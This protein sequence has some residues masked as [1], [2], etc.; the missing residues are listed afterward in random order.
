MGRS[1][2]LADGTLAELNVDSNTLAVDATNDRV[3]IGTSSPA[4]QLGFPIGNNTKISQA[5][6]TAHLAGNVGSL[7]LTISD[8]GG[9]SG[10]FVNNTHNGTYSSQD[11]T[12]LTAQGGISVATERMRIDSSGRVTM[13]YQPSFRAFKTSSWSTGNS[14]ITGWSTFHNTGNHLNTSTGVFTA[15]VAGVYQVSFHWLSDNT[16]TQSDVHIRLNNAPNNGIRTRSASSGGHQTTSG[17]QSIYMSA[18]DTLNF[19]FESGDKVY[20]DAS[21]TWTS[22][23]VTLLG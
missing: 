15:P 13:P 7:G 20:M 1:R 21:Q 18:N 22:W 6:T 2:D 16:T 10:V 23:S 14:V 19:F 17:S 3:G 5:F 4:T 8:G 11:I 12:F 9:H